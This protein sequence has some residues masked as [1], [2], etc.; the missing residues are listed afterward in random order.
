M[1]MY[2]ALSLT[3]LWGCFPVMVSS[4]TREYYIAAVVKNWN[5]ASTGQNQIKGIPL[6][7]DR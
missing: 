3:V 1:L 5:Y 7:D 2:L 4:V 6:R